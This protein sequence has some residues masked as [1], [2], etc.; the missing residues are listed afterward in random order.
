MQR[1]TIAN[2]IRRGGFVSDE[3]CASDNVNNWQA[4]EG[5][6]SRREKTAFPSKSFLMKRFRPSQCPSFMM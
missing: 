5:S 6:E 1:L 4:G 2:C 3:L